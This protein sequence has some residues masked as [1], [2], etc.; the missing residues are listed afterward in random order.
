MVA[1]A[2]TSP[3]FGARRVKE[4]IRDFYAAQ[5]PYY[6]AQMRVGWSAAVED[7]PDPVSYLRNAPLALDVFPRIAVHVGRMLSMG[8]T[9]QTES[10]EWATTYDFTVYSWVKADPAT[11]ADGVDA[12]NQPRWQ[13]AVDQRDLLSAAVRWAAADKAHCLVQPIG[14]LVLLENSFVETYTD[15]T[16]V[17][18]D[19]WVC[20]A[21]LAGRVRVT[22]S[23]P[24]LSLATV[25]TPVVTAVS[26]VPSPSLARPVPIHPALA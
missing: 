3:P 17:G 4:Q 14:T 21:S 20:G 12:E 8:R 7:S 24:T 19:R 18:G 16:K 2:P 22:E 11:G 26:F 25:T 5:L 1:L 13:T 15:P 10:P 23:L 6:L 9:E